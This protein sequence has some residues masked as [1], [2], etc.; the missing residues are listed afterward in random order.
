MWISELPPELIETIAEFAQRRHP[1]EGY[2]T[3]SSSL[4][5]FSSAS[6]Y[7]RTISTPILFREIAVTSEE[8]IWAL[9]RV[10]KSFLA[11]TR[12]VTLSI[13]HDSIFTKN[14]AYQGAQCVPRY[15]PLRIS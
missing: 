6:R 1:R 8:E 4:A 15:P 7:L 10:E 14:L 13:L 3:D 11:R 9:S 12:Q 5:A 2:V